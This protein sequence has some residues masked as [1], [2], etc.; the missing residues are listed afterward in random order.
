SD[1][2]ESGSIEQDADIVLLLHQQKVEKIDPEEKNVLKKANQ[3]VSEKQQEVVKKEAGDNSV[4]IDLIV[5][6]NR[7][8]KT[9]KVPLLFCKNICLFSNPSR[10]CEEAYSNLQNERITYG[11]RD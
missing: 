5:A 10:Q 11:N 2:R 6:K 9:G 7:A 3:E 8:G 1:L 4:M